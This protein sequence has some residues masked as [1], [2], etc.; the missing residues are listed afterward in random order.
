V[1]L[2]STSCL[3]FS[4]SSLFAR[5]PP[6]ALQ[7]STVNRYRVAPSTVPADTPRYLARLGTYGHKAMLVPNAKPRALS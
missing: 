6:G 3:L 7:G 2:V 1:V 5:S 4:Q